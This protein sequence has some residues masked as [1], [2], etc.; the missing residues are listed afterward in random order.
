MRDALVS[1][2]RNE[3]G[4]PIKKELAT[5]ETSL[6]CELRTKA[7]DMLFYSRQQIESHAEDI[8]MQYLF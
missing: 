5:I 7:V 2:D 8:G 4:Y 1:C 6:A 3:G